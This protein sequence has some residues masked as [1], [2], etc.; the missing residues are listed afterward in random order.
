MRH[1]TWLMRHVIDIHVI[2]VMCWSCD[3][4]VMMG[5]VVAMEMSL[6]LE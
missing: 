3:A 6:C 5:P 4:H 1:V 2:D